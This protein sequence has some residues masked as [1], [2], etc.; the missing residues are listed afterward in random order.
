M[1]KEE[2]IFKLKDDI[3]YFESKCKEWAA[4]I[5]ATKKCIAIFKKQLKDLCPPKK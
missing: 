1:S 3:Q 4:E 2:K 5:R